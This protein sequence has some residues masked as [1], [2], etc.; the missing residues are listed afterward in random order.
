MS[1]WM[2]YEGYFLEGHTRKEIPAVPSVRDCW[3]VCLREMNFT[4]LSVAYSDRGNLS[5]MLYDT[6]ALSVYDN[7][8]ST[9]EFTYYEYCVNGTSDLHDDVSKWKHFPR[10]WPFV[11]GIHRSPLNSHKRL[12]KQLW[13]WWFETP[14]RPLW[15]HCNSLSVLME[16]SES[17]NVVLFRGLV[18]C[19]TILQEGPW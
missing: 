12:S 16:M 14:L 3:A 11:R 5:C 10:Y 6:N 19:R 13:G 7:W 18:N 1:G 17:K 15:R 8:T 4:C 2:R 9:P